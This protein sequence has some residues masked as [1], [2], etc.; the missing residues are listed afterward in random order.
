METCGNCKQ[1]IGE[2]FSSVGDPLSPHI[3]AFTTRQL[4]VIVCEEKEAL[5]SPHILLFFVHFCIFVAIRQFENEA[6]FE[7]PVMQNLYFVGKWKKAFLCD[8][9]LT[10]WW[11]LMF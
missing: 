3:H 8:N 6:Y 7:F 5:W 1:T 10:L 11:W 2:W 4:L 9:L